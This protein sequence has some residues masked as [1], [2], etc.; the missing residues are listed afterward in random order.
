MLVLPN[1]DEGGMTALT[2]RTAA[3]DAGAVDGATLAIA[4]D[5]AADALGTAGAAVAKQVELE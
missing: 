3:T 1:G 5:A 4:V 2:M